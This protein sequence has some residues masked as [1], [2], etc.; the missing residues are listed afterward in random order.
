[1]RQGEAGQSNVN[2]GE[3]GSPIPPPAGG[4]GPQAG[5]WGNRVSP[6]PHSREGLGGR[7][8]RAGVWG[9]RVSPHSHLVGGV[10]RAQPS[11]EQ[12][13]VHPVGVR[14]S[15][16]NN[17]WDRAGEVEAPSAPSAGAVRRPCNS[18]MVREG[19]HFLYQSGVL[20]TRE[21]DRAWYSRAHQDR[22]S[23][24][25]CTVGNTAG[26]HGESLCRCF[27]YCLTDGY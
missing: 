7:S 26:A 27:L 19:Q 6:R 18:W 5:V 4:P 17:G 11:Q 15:R 8:P 1:M 2:M 20:F 12:P 13:C 9:N 21:R 24:R 23:D 3:P 22:K 25:S 10:G 16:T 14:R